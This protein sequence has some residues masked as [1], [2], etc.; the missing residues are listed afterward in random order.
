[1]KVGK[2]SI[3]GTGEGWGEKSMG[4]LYPVLSPP[5]SSFLF[6]SIDC[7]DQGGTRG[8]ESLSRKPRERKNIPRGPKK[9]K[10]KKMLRSV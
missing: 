9:K 4:T 5:P 8:K 1:M 6:N 3:G 2:T 10:D 7:S